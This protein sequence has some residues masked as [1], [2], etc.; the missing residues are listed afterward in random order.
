MKSVLL[1]LIAMLAVRCL[2][3]WQQPID[4]LCLEIM[5]LGSMG[6]PEQYSSVKFGCRHTAANEIY[7]QRASWDNALQAATLLVLRQPTMHHT[8]A[9]CC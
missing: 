1:P 4:I 5:G 3:F 8:Q 6:L 2:I 9:E 7:V